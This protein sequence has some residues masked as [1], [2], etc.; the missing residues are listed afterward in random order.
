MA[1]VY[2]YVCPLVALDFSLL[3]FDLMG[4]K[5]NAAAKRSATKE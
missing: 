3:W 2:I 5:L 4:S 1:Q